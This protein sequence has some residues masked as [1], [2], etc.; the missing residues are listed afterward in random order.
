MNVINI[1]LISHG[2]RTYKTFKM[3]LILLF[4][5]IYV[6]VFIPTRIILQFVL[7]EIKTKR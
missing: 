7:M 6:L 2:F 4:I 5:V 3:K 1:E